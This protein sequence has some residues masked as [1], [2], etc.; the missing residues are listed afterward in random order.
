MRKKYFMTLFFNKIFAKITIFKTLLNTN[1]IKL[2]IFIS[3][4]NFYFPKISLLLKKKLYNKRML[5]EK[6]KILRKVE[7]RTEIS[8]EKTKKSEE[9]I[10]QKSEKFEKKSENW[11]NFHKN[12][13]KKTEKFGEENFAKKSDSFERKNF[14]KNANS[15]KNLKWQQFIKISPK[16]FSKNNE[17]LWKKH[18]FQN[19]KNFTTIS[20]NKFSQNNEIKN[21]KENSE[22]TFQKQEVQGGKIFS[23]GVY[24]NVNDGE[25]I[26]TNEE[27][28]SLWKVFITCQAWLETLVRKD[29]EKI[30]LKNFEIRDRIVRASA[31]EKQIY[32]ALIWNRFANRVYLE[33]ASEKVETFDELFSLIEAISWEKYLPAGIA[34]VT[35]A[36]AI[37]ST[38]SHT[39][40]IQSI[41][42]K[43]IVK[44][45][46]DGTGTHRLYEDRTGDEA[47]IQIF[48]IENMA[49]ILLDITGNALHKRGWRTESGEAPIKETL[50][51]AI[52]ALS[53]WKFRDKFLD[54]FCGSGTIAIEAALLGRNIAPG[55]GRHFAIEN[56]RNFN[57][58]LFDE[59]RREAREKIFPSGNYRIFGSDSD[60]ETLQK[61]KNNAMR[62][63]VESDIIFEKSDFFET[64][65][66][67]KTHIVTNPPYNVRLETDD[68]F[69]KNFLEKMLADEI[70][71]GFITS[72]ECEKNPNI[73]HFKDR[74]LYNGG[75]AARF[76]KKN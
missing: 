33:L 39:P 45:L 7:K 54:P 32:E 11:K 56:F 67:E 37:K 69:Y 70:F 65:F 57:K 64:N 73:K 55:I 13:F 66:S 25:K 12:N 16:N 44:R 76:Y 42:K 68:E 53:G 36:T 31:T 41:A 71:G 9:K 23:N 29:N 19:E 63:G 15:E 26:E 52:V 47:H 43:A 3:W 8:D 60:E 6:I 4:Y 40:S 46:T 61:A 27:I 28:R 74:K 21:K 35:E 24:W 20:Q 62:A 18:D 59:V 50:A 34:I 58:N 22:K 38:L 14:S 2:F 5:H 48:V 10:F 30:G 1:F 72:Y 49:Y 75:L 51:A 17:N